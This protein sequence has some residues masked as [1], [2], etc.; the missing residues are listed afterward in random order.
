MNRYIA[1]SLLLLFGGFPVQSKA[2]SEAER[3]QQ[4]QALREQLRAVRDQHRELKAERGSAEQVYNDL[5]I[6]LRRDELRLA[7][8]AQELVGAD[9]E[10]LIK[11]KQL[12]EQQKK[13]IL[14]SKK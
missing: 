3:A 11:Q 10:I 1:V 8:L 9:A 14:R 12:N 7:E 13:V 5:Q 2:S 4:E 6:N